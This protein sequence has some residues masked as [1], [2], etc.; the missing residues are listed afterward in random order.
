MITDFIKIF[1]KNI[2]LLDL[3]ENAAQ[4]INLI[5][6]TVISVLTWFLVI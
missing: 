5:Y 1:Y 4:K 6:E 3:S 2:F